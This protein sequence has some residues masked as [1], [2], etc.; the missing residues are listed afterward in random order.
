[1]KLVVLA[2][3][4]LSMAACGAYTFGGEQPSPTA[5]LATVSGHVVAVPCRPIEQP[6]ATCAGRPVANLEIDYL[7]GTTV[8]ARSVTN[9]DGGYAVAVRPGSYDVAFKST[10]MRVISGPLKLTLQAGSSVTA[11]YVLDSGLRVPVPAQ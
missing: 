8:E 5:A 7:A 6:G 1:M 3:V 4:A 10:V 11:N 2:A 9:A